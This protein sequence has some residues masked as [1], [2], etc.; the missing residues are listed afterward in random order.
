MCGF[1]TLP[2]ADVFMRTLAR[3]GCFLVAIGFLTG[4]VTW[5]L[6]GLLA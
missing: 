6:W 5:W 1:P 2:D 3:I 4:L